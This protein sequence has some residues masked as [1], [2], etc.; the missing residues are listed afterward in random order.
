MGNEHSVF[1][2]YP[3]S[4]SIFGCLSPV[5]LYHLQLT[6]FRLN[7]IIINFNSRAY[8]LEDVLS[9]FFEKDE[10]T[11]FR[12]MQK[13]TNAFISGSTAL[14]FFSREVFE[15]CDLDLYVEKGQETALVDWLQSIHYK[16]VQLIGLTEEEMEQVEEP[17]SL[18]YSPYVIQFLKLIRGEKRIEVM[19]IDRSPLFAIFH[20][21]LTCVHNFITYEGAMSLYPYST[22][23][24]RQ[25]LF[26]PHVLGERDGVFCQKYERRGWEICDAPGM[27]H[28]MSSSVDR[29]VG[30]SYCWYQPISSKSDT[31]QKL[32]WRVNWSG[33]GVASIKISKM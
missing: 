6:C 15:G 7:A 14:Q 26:L 24:D 10:Y 11:D 4:D 33:L 28:H 5:D 31:L 23:H 25:A 12:E 32:S 22:F 8:H 1:Q 17:P 13:S 27:V 20:F 19:V 29:Q 18:F 16:L 9:P 2:L 21:A 3:F 30:D